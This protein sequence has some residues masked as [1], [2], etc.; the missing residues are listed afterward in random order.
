M[1]R[2]FHWTRQ[3]V[4]D[5]E[6]PLWVRLYGKDEANRP[7]EEHYLRSEPDGLWY[8]YR[9]TNKAFPGLI[10][11]FETY[12]ARP[13]PHVIAQAN[14]VSPSPGIVE[15]SFQGKTLLTSVCSKAGSVWKNTVDFHYPLILQPTRAR[16]ADGI[17]QFFYVERLIFNVQRPQRKS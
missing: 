14:I 17:P 11:R 13:G 6:D 15:V 5:G 16:T 10:G 1:T 8:R 2:E 12:Y 4:W 7:D 3:H 9:P